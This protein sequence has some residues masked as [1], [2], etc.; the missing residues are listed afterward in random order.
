MA[1]RKSTRRRP[2]E[3]RDAVLTVLAD[4]PN[5]ARVREIEQSVRRLLGNAAPSSI[6]SY[7]RLNSKTLFR[8]SSR[9]NY[10]LQETPRPA[11]GVEGRA[12][13]YPIWEFGKSR[14]LNADCFAWLREQGANSFHAVVT[15]PPYGLVEYAPEQ[16]RKLR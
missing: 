9:G 2:G 5:G 13:E 14:L 3:V 12:G 10:T 11:Y 4:R 15:D 7:L 16:Q 1:L 8:R 6:R